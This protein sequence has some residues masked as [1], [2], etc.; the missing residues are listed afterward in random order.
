MRARKFFLSEMVFLVKNDVFRC[1]IDYKRPLLACETAGRASTDRERRG[2]LGG[3]GAGGLGGGGRPQ[4][5]PK[6]LTR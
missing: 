3:W 6:T 2:V 1:Y 5:S 4:K